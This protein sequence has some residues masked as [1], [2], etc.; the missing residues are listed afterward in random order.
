MHV[1]GDLVIL[2]GLLYSG[3]NNVWFGFLRTTE[4][5]TDILAPKSPYYLFFRSLVFCASKITSSS[6]ISLSC[7]LVLTFHLVSCLAVL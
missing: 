2:S 4:G 5:Y 6:H 3:S 7:L 1:Y